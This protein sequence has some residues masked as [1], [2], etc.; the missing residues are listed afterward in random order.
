MP[1]A[2]NKAAN[3]TKMWC[4]FKK[5]KKILSQI[6]FDDGAYSAI[7][8]Q[9]GILIG[10]KH[11]HVLYST[12][13]W[14]NTWDNNLIEVWIEIGTDSQTCNT[15]KTLK[16]FFL[17]WKKVQYRFNSEILQCKLSENLQKDIFE[18]A[19]KKFNAITIS[20]SASWILRQGI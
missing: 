20:F 1:I 8:P 3:W 11:Q 15:E 13:V 19:D 18:I 10:T 2:N 16:Y 14:S 6:V 7:G 9:K 4:K 5:E 12:L 17:V